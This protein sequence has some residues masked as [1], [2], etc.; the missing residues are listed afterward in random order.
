VKNPTAPTTTAILLACLLAAC[1][2]TPD[3][4]HDRNAL[5]GLVP[6]TVQPKNQS[7]L[8]PPALV[9]GTPIGATDLM[10]RL[11]EA[12]GSVVLEE[13][14]LDRLLDKTVKDSGVA[15]PQHDI[16]AELQ[17]FVQTLADEA[18]L[19][20]EQAQGMM[21]NIRKSRG[22]GPVR[23]A[24]LLARNAKLRALVRPTVEVSA[25][26]VDQSLAAEFGPKARIRIIAIP[27]Q[28]RA[29][30]VR[31]SIVKGLNPLLTPERPQPAPGAQAD[32]PQDPMLFPTRF[33]E[34]DGPTV[35]L[36]FAQAALASST[37][38]TSQRGG[39]IES[40]SPADSGLAPNVR[41]ALGQL[42]P[43]ELSGVITTDNGCILVLLEGL[44][45]G[46]GTPTPDDRA[47]ADAR[48]RF[49]KERLAMDRLARQLLATAQVSPMD[50]S[51]RW[52]WETRAK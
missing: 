18:K 30:E 2:Q 11:E 44:T 31:E 26:E 29:A 8:P 13:M 17:L 45:E 15:I 49:R 7:N 14:A 5:K 12:G 42:H 9:Q 3:S 25:E 32:K 50:A 34:A 24:D 46:K 51:L 28:R 41:R 22:L 16:D 10:P 43:G 21:N 48:V 6:T 47:R 52:S 1:A 36:R 35:S 38:T 39:L 40:I 37:D 20:P 23:F 33:A 4:E 19:T 27:G